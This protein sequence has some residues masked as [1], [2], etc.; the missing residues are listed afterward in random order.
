MAG[1]AKKIPS[2]QGFTVHIE[3]NPTFSE[4]QDT[5]VGPPWKEWI[6]PSGHK[7]FAET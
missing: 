6:F 5:G 7:M 1:S 2:S 3:G 4:P